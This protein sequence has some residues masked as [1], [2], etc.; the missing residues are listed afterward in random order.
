MKNASDKTLKRLEQTYRLSWYNRF[1]ARVDRSRLPNWLIYT[2]IPVLWILICLLAQRLDGSG[3]LRDWEPISFVA[4]AQIGYILFINQVLDKL[5]LLALADFKPALNIEDEKYPLLQR[6]IS[7]MPAR[8]TF[9]VTFSFGFVGIFLIFVAMSGNLDSSVAPSSGYFGI[10]I[11]LTML[12][13]WF[14]NGLF[15]YHTYHQLSVVNYIYT[16]LTKVHPFHQKELFAFSTFS[17]QTGIAFVIVTPLWIILDP[18]IVSLVISIVFALLGLIAFISP[19]IGVHNILNN[20]K[21]R[22]LDDNAKEVEKT[23]ERLMDVMKNDQPEGLE[24]VDQKLTSLE[25]ARIQIDRISTWP[26]KIETLRQI[27]AAVF[28]PLIIWLLQFF[29]AQALSG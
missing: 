7:T 3:T 24:L 5:A 18:G 16:N 13:L 2:L 29:L 28:L 12:F 23:I 1:S 22:L 4:I 14:G 27:L 19:L 8:T 15:V 26:W 17:A 25:K 9:I 6:L 11:A 20:E 10:V 21:D